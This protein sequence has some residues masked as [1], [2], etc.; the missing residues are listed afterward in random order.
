MALLREDALAGRRIAV[1]GGA[2]PA[3]ADAL[4]RI[5]ASTLQLDLDG[6][7]D[8]RAERWAGSASPLHGFVYDSAAAFGTGGQAGMQ[9]AIDSGW[10]AIRGVAAGALIPAGAGG[11][12]VLIAP[13]ADAGPN[14]EATR[15]ALENLARTLSIEWARYQIT[16]TMLAPGRQTTD[17]DLASV[18]AFL[19][20][21]GGAYFS[22]C[23]LE[24][25]AVA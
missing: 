21:P 13:A 16:T 18:V 9:A 14:V 19:L 12:N 17:A 20:S 4:E 11:T 8:E 6:L 3:I 23:R 15:S 10:P 7:D 25:D 24:L 5:G 2:R 22:G 1:A